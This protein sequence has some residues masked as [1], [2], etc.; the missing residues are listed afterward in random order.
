MNKKLRTTA[1]TADFGNLH[2]KMILNNDLAN[3]NNELNLVPTRYTSK[4]KKETS[5]VSL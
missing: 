1:S 2:K 5:K 3:S 4:T